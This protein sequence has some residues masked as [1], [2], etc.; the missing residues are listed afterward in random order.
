MWAHRIEID[1]VRDIVETECEQNARFNARWLHRVIRPA[2]I[3][4]VNHS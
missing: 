2:R 3:V 4:C 1:A